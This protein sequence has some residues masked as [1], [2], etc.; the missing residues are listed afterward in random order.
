MTTLG[1][2]SEMLPSIF[3]KNLARRGYLRRLL[4]EQMA[5]FLGHVD[6]IVD[7]RED[8]VGVRSLESKNAIPVRVLASQIGG[9]SMQ[10][11]NYMSTI[12]S[13]YLRKAGEHDI[14]FANGKQGSEEYAQGYRKPGLG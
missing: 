6:Q 5:S 7:T 9:K 4:P 8:P 3:L 12:R 1:E 10:D 2:H 11:L 13:E 14:Q